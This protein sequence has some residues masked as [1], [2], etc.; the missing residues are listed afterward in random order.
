MNWLGSLLRLSR[1]GQKQVRT[2]VKAKSK[3]GLRRVWL[4][5]G[6]GEPLSVLANLHWGPAHPD[7]SR[8]LVTVLLAY[9]V[10]L[11]TP[12]HLSVHIY[13][14]LLIPPLRPFLVGCLC[15]SFELRGSK[16]YSSIA[17]GCSGPRGD[18]F[19]IILPDISLRPSNNQR[20]RMWLPYTLLDG[21]KAC[22]CYD[23]INYGLGKPCIPHKDKLSHR[24]WLPREFNLF[25]HLSQCYS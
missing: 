16:Q 18:A 23:Q 3:R 11:L 5:F 19:D 22:A 14:V 21:A 15:T 20:S 25:F 24:S 17:L 8:A 13:S 9:P 12:L 4:K 6:Q 7:W 2:K 10:E 1:E